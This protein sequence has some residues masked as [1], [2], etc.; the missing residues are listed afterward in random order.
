MDDMEQ[1]DGQEQMPEEVQPEAAKETTELT[2]ENPALTEPTEGD[3]EPTE[4]AVELP[5]KEKAG[6]NWLGILVGLVAFVGVLAYCWMLPGGSTQQDTGVLYAK[7]DNLYYYDLKQEPFLLAEDISDGGT[8]HYFYTAWGAEV[9]EEGDWVY[10]ADDID[11]AGRFNLYRKNG[12]DAEAEKVDV[13]V[14]D[15]MTSKNGEVVAYLAEN[16]QEALELRVYDGK[17]IRTI[18]SEMKL[19]ENTYSLSADGKYLVYRD[20]YQ[21]LSAGNLEDTST[22]WKKL[23][24]D[25]PIYALTEG[26]GTLYYAARAGEG[27]DLY[28]YQM[29]GSEPTQLAEKIFS[30]EIMPNGRDVLYCKTP[31][32][33]ILYEDI[34]IDDMAEADAE[35]T[36]ADGEAYEKKKQRDAIREA[37]AKGEDFEPLLQEC[38]VLT[39]G[40]SV[41]VA[42]DVVSAIAVEHDRPYVIGYKAKEF[43]PLRL[44]VMDGGLDMVEYIYYMSLSYGGMETFLTDTSGKM[45][46]LSGYQVQPDSIRLSADGSRAAYLTGNPNTEGNILMQQELGKETEATAVAENVKSFSFVGKDLFYYYDY[47]NGTGTVGMAGAEKTIPNAS[48]V[49]F[50]ED[51]VYYI[52]NADS[53]TGN[54][55]LNYWKG[56]EETTIDGGVFAFQ[57]KANG[58]VVFLS[59]YDV[60]KE[61]GDLNYYDGKGVTALDTDVT[62]L[63]ID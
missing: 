23:T 17:E 1:K 15:Y 5:K 8:Y 24:D 50:T 53:T 35:L 36:E 25:S 32:E 46:L 12:K 2:E 61:L 7:E 63:F 45:Q 58:K 49:Q 27:Y 13:R 4:E 44:S 40:K 3:A 37:I 22:E 6:A 10:F 20:A 34:I 60:Q 18:S 54:G 9:T 38:Y 26:S 43:T 28:A 30:M 48:G 56:E 29:D 41:K 39:G 11:E 57:C 62:A 42:N 21:I 51:A 47:A 52:A 31:T 19:T 59:Q 14:Y 55:Q 16:E 33:K